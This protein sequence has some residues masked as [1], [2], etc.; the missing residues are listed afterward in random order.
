M[1]KNSEFVKVTNGMIYEKILNI[2]QQVIKTNG[3]IKTHRLWLN[4]LS[5]SFG[6]MIMFILGILFKYRGG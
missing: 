4:I 5:G 2:E 3:T 1:P 6:T